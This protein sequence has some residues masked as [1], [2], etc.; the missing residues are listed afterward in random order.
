[1]L[2]DMEVFELNPTQVNVLSHLVPRA[3]LEDH[4]KGL[5]QYIVGQKLREC[6]GK[7]FEEW[8]PKLAK[9]GVEQVPLMDID[10]AK[11][12]FDRPDYIVRTPDQPVTP[13]ATGNT[14]A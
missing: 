10:L 5:I 6:A 14:E 11:M 13:I 8:K 4:I 2:D 1:M 12:I 7:L 3:E 9:E